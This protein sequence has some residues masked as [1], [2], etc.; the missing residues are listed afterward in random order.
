MDTRRN[1]TPCIVCN[2]AQRIVFAVCNGFTMYRCATCKLLYLDPIPENHTAIYDKEYFMGGRCGYGYPNYED[3]KQAAVRTF[4]HYLDSIEKHAPCGALSDIGA[5]TGFFAERARARG[6]NASG[7]EISAY[8]RGAM[9]EKGLPSY[10][11]VSEL[12]GAFGTFDAVTLLDTI[13]HA[14]DP[15]AMLAD[16]Y[17][18][19]KTGGV[20]ALNTPDAGSWFARALGARWHLI[21]PP[22]HT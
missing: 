22:E 2:S 20:L 3:E 8:A 18:L 14:A 12:A 16:A 1:P 6:W 17:R 21:I 11:S 10:R 13:E 7:V 9:S 5:A 15:R 19:L 4:E